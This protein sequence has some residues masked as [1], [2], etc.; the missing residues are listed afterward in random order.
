[1]SD[2]FYDPLLERAGRIAEEYAISISDV[3]GLLQ[4]AGRD[5][6]RVRDALT[7]GMNSDAAKDAHIAG[8]Q[9]DLVEHARM[10]LLHW[11]ERQPQ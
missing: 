2:G 1:M 4:R 10:L 11:A 6:T 3:M 5:E 9:F 8:R 7:A